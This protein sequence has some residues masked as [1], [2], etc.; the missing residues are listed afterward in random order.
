MQAIAYW[1]S[2]VISSEYTHKH[3][4]TLFRWHNTRISYFDMVWHCLYYAYWFARKPAQ[5][6]NRGTHKIHQINLLL[7][8]DNDDVAAEWMCWTVQIDCLYIVALCESVQ[9]YYHVHCCSSQWIE[10][11]LVLLKQIQ[12]CGCCGWRLIQAPCAN[13]SALPDFKA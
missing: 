8:N 11:L 2:F 13:K 1:P 4:N 5:W 3:I 10:C 6:L 9:Y 7:P 12:T